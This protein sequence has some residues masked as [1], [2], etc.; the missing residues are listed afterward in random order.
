MKYLAFIVSLA[1]LLLFSQAAN[2]GGWHEPWHSEVLAE[3][4]T[5]GLYSVSNVRESGFKAKL[6]KHIAG[7]KPAE[8]IDVSIAF[9]HPGHSHLNMP[10]GKYYLFLNAVTDQSTPWQ[11]AT[12]MAGIAPFIE[13]DGQAPVTHATYRISMHQ[14]LVPAAFYERTQVCA[15]RPAQCDKETQKELAEL[16]TQP[17]AEIEGTDE[18]EM[19]RFFKQHAALETAYLRKQAVPADILKPFLKGKSTHVQISAIRALRYSKGDVATQLVAAVKN[20]KL[21]TLSRIFAVLMLRELD[22]K[23]SHAAL[24]RYAA[25][26]PSDALANEVSLVGNI[27]DPRIYTRFPRTIRRAIA[28]LPAHKLHS[29]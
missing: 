22:D 17:V 2:A 16:L 12:P 4:D 28:W 24:R 5:F 15:F 11:I 13:V 26:M 7:T 19:H 3:A 23:P 21:A 29:R 18:A 25:S 10:N 6:I 1:N 8:K 20:D 14:A 9:Q 27:M